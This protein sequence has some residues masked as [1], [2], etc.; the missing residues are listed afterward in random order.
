MINAARTLLLNI[1][2]GD[3]GYLLGPGEEFIPPE[4]APV[5]R[6][7][8]YL[9]GLRQSLFG[10][11]PDRLYSN[12]RGQQYLALIAATELQS[13]VTD[14][15]PRITYDVDD[16]LLF[17]P[18]IFSTVASPSDIEIIGTAPTSAETGVSRKRWRI[19]VLD[20]S[21]VSIEKLGEASSST[22]RAYTVA[23]D[24]L[25]DIIPIQGSMSVRLPPEI[26]R[27]WTITNTFR[28]ARSLGEVADAIER[29]SSQHLNSLFGVG[30][31]AGSSEPYQTFKNLW[32]QHPEL[33]HRLGGLLLAV[34]YRMHELHSAGN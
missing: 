1:A 16:L 28:P 25:T 17:Y 14:L 3:N 30:T 18:D 11:N 33:P 13:F 8:T 23:T 24:G 21:Q 22:E 31:P 7:P 10:Q 6:I 29:S 20:S 9:Q 4:F 26:G 34:I 15:D 12:Y 19:T 32:E 27:A 2:P 5:T